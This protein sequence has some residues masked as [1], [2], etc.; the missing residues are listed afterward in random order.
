ML[1]LKKQTVAVDKG[2]YSNYYRPDRREYEKWLRYHSVI[3]LE[4]QVGI[5][6]QR[7]NWANTEPR[8][9]RRWD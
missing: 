4:T 8:T 2:R 6:S 5:T 3:S 9:Y 7:N 1:L